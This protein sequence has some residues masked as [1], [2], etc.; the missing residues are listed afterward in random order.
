ML[1][2]S[3]CLCPCVLVCSF[4]R[5]HAC[6]CSLSLSMGPAHTG[7]RSCSCRPL[8]SPFNATTHPLSPN[9]TSTT[10]IPPLLLPSQVLEQ[11]GLDIV[12]RDWCP[13]SKDCGNFALREIL[14]GKPREE[15]GRAE[16]GRRGGGGQSAG[17]GGAGADGPGGRSLPYAL[18]A[19][20]D[21][22]CH[23]LQPRCG[24]CASRAAQESSPPCKHAAH[25][26]RAAPVQVVAAIHSHLED[27]KGKVR[28]CFV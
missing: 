28:D 23:E 21:L 12:R 5:W 4:A 20:S 24:V 6:V 15:V 25:A 9:N 2:L 16:R 11:K 19:R 3:I 17:G 27:V 1:H 18:P 26:V 14:S 10:P 22:S 8:Q 7:D 13:L